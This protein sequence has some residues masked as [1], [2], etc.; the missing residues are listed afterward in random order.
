[1]RSVKEKMMNEDTKVSWTVVAGFMALTL[2]SVSLSL[3]ACATAD[4]QVATAVATPQSQMTNA[5]LEQKIK[6]KFNTD[7]KL[8]SANLNVYA[9]V[10]YHAV[11]ISG[12]VESVAL[13]IKAVELA[14]STEAGLNVATKIDVKP[15]ELSPAK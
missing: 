12:T 5:E 1:M 14:R 9:N 13:R 2:L 4:S 6:A 3:N 7:A 15:S 11:T 10:D 8:K